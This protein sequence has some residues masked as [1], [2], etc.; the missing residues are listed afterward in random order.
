MYKML[1]NFCLMSLVNAY[2]K[3]TLKITLYL[4][5][6]WAGKRLKKKACPRST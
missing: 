2:L 5:S 6:F 3:K 4:Y 1:C